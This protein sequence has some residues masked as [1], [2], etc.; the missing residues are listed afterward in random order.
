M[1]L[2][3]TYLIIFLFT[4]FGAGA[5]HNR[6]GSITYRHISGYTYEFTITTCTKTSS[7]A[8]RPELQV[9]W[10]DGSMDTIPR[11]TPID[12]IQAYDVQINTYI[13]SHTFTGPSSYIISV[14][15]PNRNSNILNITNSVD[16]VF[17]IQTELVISPFIGTPNNS[18]VIE[19]C[20]C[21][22]FACLN[23]LY[24][25]N[26]SAYDPD[27]DSLSYSLVP[28][29]G[30]DCLEMIM[31][32]IYEYPDAVGGGTMTIDP[33]TGTLCWDSPQF[34][35]EYNLAI[36]ITEWRNGFY[37][38]SVIQDMQLTVKACN[39][40]PPVI[41]DV[42]D[43]CVFA[44]NQVEIDFVAADPNAGDVV[45]VSATGAIFNVGNNPALFVD[46]TAAD[47]AVGT[48]MWL[49]NCED[50]TNNYYNI[51]VHA[52]DNDPNVPL[53]DLSTFRI[54]VNIPPVQNVNV[55][56]SGSTMVINWNPSVCGNIDHYNIYRNTDSLTEAENCCSN[57]AAEGLG[58]ELVG[59]TTDTFY[60]DNS[61][62][63]VGNDYCYLVTAVN[64]N[65]VESCLSNIDC[66]HLN[67]EIPVLTHVSINTTNPSTGTDTVKWAYP[68]EL[69]TLSFTGPYHYQLYRIQ[70]YSGTE[71]LV[72]TTSPQTSII[73]PD[74]TFEDSNLDTENNP[75]T[76]R[77]E[78]YN[79]G[80][81]V[82]SSVTASSIYLSLTP[83]DNQLELNWTES[84][85]WNNT[86]YEI[87]R[88]TFAGSGIF[89]LI[90]TTNSIGYV[91]TG[92]V[93]GADYCYKIKTIG[94]YSSGGIVNPIENWSQEVCGSPI[95][96]TAPCPPELFI[97]GDCDVEETYLTWTNPNNSCADDVMSYN[98]YF[99]AFEGDSLEFLTSFNS[100]F[101]TSFT[102]A[103]RGSI[104]GCYY[105]T[106]IDSA[107][108]GNES[109]PSN[110]ACIDNCDGVYDLP[111]VFTPDNSGANDLYHPLLPYKFVDHIELQIFSRWGDLVYETTDPQIDWDGVNLEGKVCNDG[112]YFYTITV[113]E[114]K[115]SGLVSREFQGNITIINSQH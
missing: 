99:A 51:I 35:G 1:R 85:P 96:L 74:T 17:C 69:D 91:D 31:P 87:Y 94:S 30:E 58:Y 18:L 47:T 5:T 45:T 38:G 27:G 40:D 39:N 52:V 79:D 57:G 50:A 111:N 100:Q 72:L 16:K 53:E 110:I 65:G 44:G 26:L 64:S 55:T 42:S 89:N 97:D 78:L 12:F 88:E 56:P 86:S 105:I 104:A 106:A 114:I 4:A 22:E 54:K 67:F 46:S 19:D 61:P 68:K 23:K 75:Y 59:T 77:V 25:Y 34:Q 33:I 93:N 73:N 113:Y 29:R 48:F 82:G 41:K 60:I 9:S 83:N 66:E 36:K 21:P 7:D 8:D 15:D 32:E 24:C 76:Y 107:Q 63:V 2:K 112:V 13:G 43:T 62:I 80:I 98:L 81:L 109:E 70:G 71:S 6:S 37:V 84:I 95:D 3:I 10:G 101:D 115:L 103:D 11:Q 90:G 49:P 14:E 102:H 20:P 108:Y 28:C 92:L